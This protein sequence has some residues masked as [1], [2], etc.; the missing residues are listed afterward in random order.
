MAGPV[1][2]GLIGAGHWGK[3]Y[4]KTLATLEDRCRLTHLCTS[5]PENAALAP[6]P[7]TVVMNW[8]E[9]IS[10]DCDAVIIATPPHTHAEILEACLAAR[11]PCL[12]E[13]PLCVDL[14]T[15]ERLHRQ[16]EASGVPVLVD[17]THLFD[18]AYQFLKRTVEDVGE[19]IRVILSEGMGWGPFRADTPALWDWG[20]H[21][22]SLCLD[23]T[24]KMPQGVHALG[25]PSG[26]DGMPELL[27]LRLD[28]SD[29]VCA[30]IHTG[31]LAEHK[32]RCLSV[33]TDTRFYVFNALA[34][35]RL[36]VRTID[37]VNRYRRPTIDVVEASRVD[38]GSTQ[39]ALA[40]LV[41][42][43][44]TGLEGGDRSRFGTQLSYDVVRV[45]STCEDTLRV[46]R[47]QP[48]AVS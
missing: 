38:L 1:R 20:P 15:A 11:K 41:S 34:A 2:F 44:I 7:V 46:S 13:K 18:S 45:L 28:F 40:N 9:L 10:A 48:H 31:R 5:K 6:H 30:W 16:V 42:Y 22:V 27:S 3:V 19:P 43:F 29:G 39:P 32:R 23:L 24:G 37:F 25:G 33:M 36:T 8:H 21:D 17:H 35:D 14:A 47:G 12:V 4:L 26:H